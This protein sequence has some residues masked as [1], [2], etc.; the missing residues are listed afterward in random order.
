MLASRQKNKIRGTDSESLRTRREA[1]LALHKHIVHPHPMKSSRR[2]LPLPFA[3]VKQGC[4]RCQGNSEGSLKV[5]QLPPFS[6]C[7]CPSPDACEARMLLRWTTGW[8]V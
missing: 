2:R 8:C 1:S 6:S 7:V 4:E 3:A 5:Q